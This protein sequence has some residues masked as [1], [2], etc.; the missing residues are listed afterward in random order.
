MLKYLS[1]GLYKEI[2]QK[3]LYFFICAAGI[4]MFSF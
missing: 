2:D 3:G 1:E 4:F